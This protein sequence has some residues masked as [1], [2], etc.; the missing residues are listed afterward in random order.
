M[1]NNIKKI[2]A[3]AM[4]LALLGTGTAL[5]EAFLPN[6]NTGITVSAAESNEFTTSWETVSSTIYFDDGTTIPAGSAKVSLV[7]L[8]AKGFACGGIR[9]PFNPNKEEIAR[10]K[11]GNIIVIYAQAGENKYHHISVNDNVN[12]KGNRGLKGIIGFGYSGDT[13]Y[14]SGVVYSVYLKPKGNIDFSKEKLSDLIAEPIVERTLDAKTYPIP[15]TE[16][17]EIVVTGDNHPII[18]NKKGKYTFTIGDVNND[19]TID[20][21]DA[22]TIC[23][24]LGKSESLFVNSELLWRADVTE[25][26]VVTMDDAFAIL[27]YYSNVGVSGNASNSMY[28]IGIQNTATIAS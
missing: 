5:T 20:V 7:L 27:D 1:K 2:T 3:A 16:P 10:D 6:T 22:Q 21:K 14:E 23:T 13:S 15:H 24:T 28:R 4:A 25:D 9:I 8:N 12:P 17:E 19:G 18:D 26:R 11:K